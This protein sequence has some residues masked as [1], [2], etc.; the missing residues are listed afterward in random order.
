VDRLVQAAVDDTD[1]RRAR[2]FLGRLTTRDAEH[3]IVNKWRTE[4]AARTT[5]QMDLA[6]AS[7]AGNDPAQAS[8]LVDTAARIWPD[9][10]G[11]RDLHRELTTRYQILRVGVLEL[12][13][14]TSRDP[15]PSSAQERWRVLT[16]QS[17]FETNR[18]DES[19]ARYRSV[20]CEDWEP[21]D[22][23]RELR[24]TLR[25]DRADWETRPKWTSATLAAE[26]SARLNP[27]HALFDERLAANVSGYATPSPFELTVQF[28]RPPLKPEA[29]FRLPLSIAAESPELNA[30]LNLD[31]TATEL[32]FRAIADGEHRQRGVRV[33]PEPA[34]AKQR[35]V[36]E[37]TEQKY[38]SWEKLLQ[39]LQ[40]GEISAAVR[41]GHVDLAGL[42][43]D[44]RFFVLPYAQPTSHVIQIHPESLALKNGQLRRA[45]LHALPRENLLHEELLPGVSREP[46]VARLSA[47]PFTMGTPAAN[48]LL[49]QPEYDL[50][51]SA[52]L[53]ATARKAFGGTLPTLRI[54][55]PDDVAVSRTLDKM[56][57]HW[58]RIGIEVVPITSPQERWDL[59][60]RTIQFREPM[61][62]LW[63]FLT[64]DPAA[65][66]T[67]LTPFP[68][69]LRRQLLE[70]ERATDYASALQILH[71]LQSDLLIDAWWIPLWEVDDFCLVRRNISG[72][73]ERPVAPYHDVERWV[74]QP[75][76]PQDQP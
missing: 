10:Q 68:E 16:S 9:T 56:I 51:L 53:A 17:W 41:I 44:P 54:A 32:R 4:L 27:A 6:R 34:T 67:S 8:E 74:V 59:A 61:V 5:A 20:P 11:L 2:H 19:G 43:D 15:F 64:L 60:Y 45:L 69:R 75:W 14:E 70:M 39:A 71:R 22:L 66:I 47:S 7:A 3:E 25:R 37:I 57:A 1:Y 29:L 52:G 18:F 58:K 73:A 76:Y 26:L 13:G 46:V 72:L 35:H 50:I 48:R 38:E 63:P 42:K 49:P 12:P 31:A 28:R 65:R 21:D 40:R 23:G 62:E 24:F 36:A 30:D 33:R 55:C